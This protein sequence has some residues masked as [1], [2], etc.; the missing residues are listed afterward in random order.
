MAPVRDH[1]AQLALLERAERRLD[2]ALGALAV[3][4]D[5]RRRLLYIGRVVWA[6]DCLVGIRREIGESMTRLVAG[7]GRDDT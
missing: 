6:A 2:V 1:A 3:A 5:V 4:T 7:Y